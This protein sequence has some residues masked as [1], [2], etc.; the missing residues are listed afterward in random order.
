MGKLF[1]PIFL[2]LVSLVVIPQAM[3]S[4]IQFYATTVQTN[5]EGKTTTGKLYVG[6]GVMRTETTQDG[7]TRI[8]IVDRNRRVA[9]IL[10]PA[11]K[12]YVEM[13]GPERRPQA[14]APSRPPLPDEPGSACQEGRQG[15]TCD[16]LGTEPMNG[17]TTDKWAFT[18][19]VQGQT[20]RSVVWIDPELRTSI[21]E[22]FQGGYVR[23]L[24]DVRVGP[25][26]ASLFAV[27]GDYAKI[28][29][30]TQS[31]GGQD[32]PPQY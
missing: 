28:D 16:K 20:S 8:T 13:K 22:E 21:R 18:R 32:G 6:D 23:E 4:D 11:K 1:L 27:P 30:P 15:L 26:P 9:W 31:R 29:M 25:P 5:P 14:E 7:Q 10:N 19:T 3:A 2:S 12:E 24:R 17:R